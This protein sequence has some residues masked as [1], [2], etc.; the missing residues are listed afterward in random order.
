MMQWKV[1]AFASALALPTAAMAG[2]HL[3][4]TKSAVTQPRTAPEYKLD[5]NTGL[6]PSN[7]PAP[8]AGTSPL[9]RETTS[10]FLGLKLTKP[11]GN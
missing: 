9:T 5:L 3:P 10:P 7:A 1:V 11:I 8:P 6:A 4:R 2:D